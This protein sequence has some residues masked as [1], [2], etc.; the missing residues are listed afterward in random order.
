[1][2]QLLRWLMLVSLIGF[3]CL[4]TGVSLSVQ[5]EDASFA[6]TE[7][8]VVAQVEASG[9]V[10]FVN[11]FIYDVKRLDEV[12]F[13][14][15]HEGYAI[16]NYRVGVQ[17]EKDGEITYLNENYSASPNTFSAEQTSFGTTFRA[18]YPLEG[19]QMRFIFEYTLDF[20]VTNYADTANLSYELVND[21]IAYSHDVT[22]RIFLPGV[23][24]NQENFKA[25]L[26]SATNSEVF[27]TVENNRSVIHLTIDDNPANQAVEVNAIFPV[28]LTPH[29]VNVI[30]K[31]MRSE[32]IADE[33]SLAD[34]EL[35]AFEQ[36]RN[37]HL[38]LLMGSIVFGPLSVLAAYGYY[39]RAREKMNP[40]RQ[41][42]PEHLYVLPEAGITPAIM[43]TSVFRGK[44]NAD[45]FT[46]TLLDLARKGFVELTEVRKERRGVFGDGE[47]STIKIS[48]GRDYAKDSP[49]ALGVT[50]GGMAP[51]LL[52][53]RQVLNYIMTGIQAEALAA[54]H[55]IARQLLA[56]D[57]HGDKTVDWVTLEQMEERSKK[58]KDFRKTQQV[59]WK[60]FSDYAELNGTKRRGRKLPEASAAQI[61]SI[62]SLLI[63]FG[64]GLLG[65]FVAVEV[66]ANGLI[67]LSVIVFLLSLAA[68]IWLNILRGR[69]P[70]VTAE[71][72]RTRQEWQ[73]F[74]K[75]L[76]DIQDI[77]VRK[78]ARL[79]SW[80]E[81]LAYAVS[82]GVIDDL[83]EVLNQQYSQEE[84]QSL[85]LDSHLITQPHLI[86]SVMRT[87]IAN[88]LS[89]I[90]PGS[91]ANGYSGGS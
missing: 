91:N 29:N 59:N 65:V 51:L 63:S 69:R 19:V 74:S 87:S 24:N 43:A 38:M 26:H 85:N 86:S 90:D 58:D 10:S 83:L 52:H 75:M 36:K 80:E 70:I 88:T 81:S 34:A 68:S 5:A 1:M 57:S 17:T 84:L 39:F 53:E 61:W 20:L 32:I 33:T 28:S 11:T 31:S 23:V 49:T 72:D 62:A 16:R 25:W 73:A 22:A 71:Q 18:H 76:T 77:D 44:P 48:M 55:D 56:D 27:L 7:Q 46:A 15:S 40:N 60:K 47:S 21:K 89:A 42:L 79:A 9:A 30:E 6:I 78:V 67:T 14:L 54:K 12:Q 13:D 45:D 50:V 66:K 64:M 82:L 37:R 41:V 3:V 35:A 4:G 8:D 2:K